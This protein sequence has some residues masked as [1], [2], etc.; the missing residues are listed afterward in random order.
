MAGRENQKG[1]NNPQFKHHPIKYFLHNPIFKRHKPL[2]IT[3]KNDSSKDIRGPQG[4]TANRLQAGTA[5]NVN[6]DK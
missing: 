5:W 6:N 4:E 3:L 2:T 1:S